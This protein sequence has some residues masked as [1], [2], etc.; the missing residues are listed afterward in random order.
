[1]FNYDH[2]IEQAR[3][4]PRP[5]AAPAGFSVVDLAQLLWQRK[6]PIVST[7][8][9]GRVK[10]RRYMSLIRDLSSILADEIFL[11]HESAI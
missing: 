7:A 10:A 4:G 1:M 11:P 8:L 3:P 2:P 6:V 9:G 5:A